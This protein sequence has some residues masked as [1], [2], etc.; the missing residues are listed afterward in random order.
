MKNLTVYIAIIGLAFLMDRMGGYLLR[1]TTEQSQFRYSRLYSGRAQA[2]ILLVGNSRGLTFYQPY[3]EEITGKK[4]FNQSYNGMPMD[5]AKVVAMDYL[6]KYPKPAVM[7]VDI[8]TCDRPNDALITGFLPYSAY[9]HRIDT[10]I[11]SKN[12]S[13]WGGG[14]LSAL[15]RYN[16]EVF[17]RALYYKSSSDADWL[18]DRVIAPKLAA[19]VHKNSYDLTVQP[20][21]VAQLVELVGYAKSKGVPVKLVISPYL[22]GFT[23]KNLPSLK[24]E[25]ERLTGLSVHDY[26]QSLTEIDQFGDFMHPNLKGSKAYIDLMQRDSLFS[27]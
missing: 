17:Q 4:T 5:L 2:D 3:I 24:A 10:L 27:E 16:N 12:A 14:A 11:K 19:E 15:Y 26:S 18:L 6:D 13:A 7:L 25:V 9:S 21:L 22:P 23:V 8:T 1:S 20:Y